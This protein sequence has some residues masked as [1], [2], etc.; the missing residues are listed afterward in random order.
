MLLPMLFHNEA[1]PVVVFHVSVVVGEGR[2]IYCH[3]VHGERIFFV[4]VLVSR[5][6]ELRGCI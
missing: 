3:S 2:V 1:A 5:E 6:T 4:V